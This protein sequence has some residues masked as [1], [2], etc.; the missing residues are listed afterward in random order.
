MCSERKEKE[1]DAADG[2]RKGQSQ[3]ISVRER[4]ASTRTTENTSTKNKITLLLVSFVE[5]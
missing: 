3:H 5:V 1:R 4:G 2:E